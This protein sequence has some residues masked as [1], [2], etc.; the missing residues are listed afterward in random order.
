MRVAYA[1][2]LGKLVIFVPWQKLFCFKTCTSLTP[3]L[4]NYSFYRFKLA[5][6]II[7]A[8][9]FIVNHCNILLFVIITKDTGN[10]TL[11]SI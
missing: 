8:D 6:P 5:N 2:P 11:G 9:F 1:I 10:S 4:Q 7:I 3:T